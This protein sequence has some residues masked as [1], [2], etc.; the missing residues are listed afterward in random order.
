MWTAERERFVGGEKVVLRSAGAHLSFGAV[1][2][3]LRADRD[4]SDFFL[5]ELAATPFETFFW[6]MPPLVACAMGRPY[7]HVTI[8]SLALRQVEEDGSAFALH[9]AEAGAGRLVTAFHSLSGGAIL[10]APLAAGPAGAN[11]HIAAFVRGAPRPQQRELLALAADLALERLSERPTWISTSGTGVHWL[12]VR[13]EGAP[14]YYVH[15]PYKV[16]DASA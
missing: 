1:L 15:R 4:F 9:L 6:E 16:Y 7:E 11:A 5:T 10:V 2:H 3:A 12:H 14:V 8:D 13:I